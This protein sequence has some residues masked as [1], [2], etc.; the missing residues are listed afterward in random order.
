MGDLLRVT[1]IKNSMDFRTVRHSKNTDLERFWMKVDKTDFCWNW[2][3]TKAN[4]YGYATWNKVYERAHRVSYLIANGPIPEGL[5]I[6]HLC[7]NRAC[8]NPEHLEAVTF[9]ENLRRG[10]CQSAINARKTKCKNGHDFS[11]ENTAIRRDNGS[12]ICRKCRNDYK[13]MVKIKKRG[14]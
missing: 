13:K 9:A 1:R 11:P 10:L 6:D 14:Y 8:V 5:V 7:R 12:R 2:L 4:G 3:G